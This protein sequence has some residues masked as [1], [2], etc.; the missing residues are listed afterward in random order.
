MEVQMEIEKV[1]R[2][3]NNFLNLFYIAQSIFTIISTHILYKILK[4]DILYSFLSIKSSKRRVHFALAIHLN[5]DAGLSAA[6][7]KC[8][9]TKT[10]KLCLLEKYFN[11]DSVLGL[12]LN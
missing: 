11:M 7:V 2:N 3:R 8:S 6:G 4:W 10:I 9:P 5:L 1:Q 12:Y